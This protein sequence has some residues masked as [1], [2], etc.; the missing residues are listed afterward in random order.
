MAEIPPQPEE[1][2]ADE[3]GEGEAAEEEEEAEAA[4]THRSFKTLCLGLRLELFRSYGSE[5]MQPSPLNRAERPDAET[6]SSGYFSNSNSSR[7]DSDASDPCFWKPRR[8]QSSDGS[9]TS[10]TSSEY[11][12]A[13]AQKQAELERQTAQVPLTEAGKPTSVGSINHPNGCCPC[14][15]FAKPSGCIR[16]VQCEFCHFP[17]QVNVKKHLSA[18]RSAASRN[19]TARGQL[20]STG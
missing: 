18:Q 4:W 17:H 11:W 16:G 1:A 14:M 8:V 2:D 12:Q 15:F 13:E 20:Y 10:A 5:A 6:G 19:G 9:V 3:P 7:S